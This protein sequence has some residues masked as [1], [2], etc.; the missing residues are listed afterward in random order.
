MGERGIR[1]NRQTSRIRNKW[2]YICKTIVSR[3][4]DRTGRHET[5]LVGCGLFRLKYKSKER[6]LG[7]ILGTH[8]LRQ[9]D[10]NFSALRAVGYLVNM[11]D[12]ILATT[13]GDRC[14]HSSRSLEW[15][16]SPSNPRRVVD[17]P[18]SDRGI[19]DRQRRVPRLSNPNNLVALAWTRLFSYFR[20]GT[21]CFRLA[22]SRSP[23]RRRQSNDGRKRQRRSSGRA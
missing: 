10:Q 13:T 8:R 5:A 1:G 4:P 6:V 14:F 9:T 3:T 15:P 18:V 19:S 16:L 2:E 23:S 21:Y 22:D 7:I 12:L 17:P 20:G 11:H